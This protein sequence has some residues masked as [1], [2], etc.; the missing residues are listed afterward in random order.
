MKH[1][2]GWQRI[3]V[4]LSCCWILVATVLAYGYWTYTGIV[5]PWNLPTLLHYIGPFFG[6]YPPGILVVLVAFV[7]PIAAGWLFVYVI[8][9]STK[10]I[11]GGF[12]SGKR[13]I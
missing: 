11:I 9:W 5:D 6:Y 7:F 13:N 4:I 10:W 2:N 3:G 1:L 12:K 8:I